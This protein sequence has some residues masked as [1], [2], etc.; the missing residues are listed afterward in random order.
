VCWAWLGAHQG[1]FGRADRIY[2]QRE[3]CAADRS[4]R[5]ADVSGID[6]LSPAVRAKAADAGFGVRLQDSVG[7][8]DR[9]HYPDLVLVVEQGRVLV[10]LQLT[11][12]GQQAQQEI[13]TACQRKPSTAA[14]LYLVESHRIGATIK[15]AAARLDWSDYVLVQKVRLDRW[16][17]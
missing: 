4:R 15:A 7:R 17:A 5:T 11:S 6:S 9:V 3:L 10:H 12:I 2:S 8:G 16:T 1:A 14:M 13:L